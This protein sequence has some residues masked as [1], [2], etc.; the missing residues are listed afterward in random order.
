MKKSEL[1]S[2]QINQTKKE[3]KNQEEIIDSLI[4][5]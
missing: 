5:N 4:K 2:T 3:E 1:T